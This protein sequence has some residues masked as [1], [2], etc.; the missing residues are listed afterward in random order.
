MKMYG[1]PLRA[2]HYSSPNHHEQP[3]TLG[4]TGDAIL[5]VLTPMAKA[6][7]VLGAL[8]EASLQALRKIFEYAQARHLTAD[9][10]WFSS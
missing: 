9:S 1:D 2:T 5:A 10:A 3:V 4:G 7:P 6:L 8:A